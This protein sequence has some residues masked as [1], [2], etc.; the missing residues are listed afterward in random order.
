MSL[1]S[2][3][4]YW[5]FIWSCIHF[6]EPT[7]LG[8]GCYRNTV[9]DIYIVSS[10]CFFQRFCPSCLSLR[11]SKLLFF[12]FC[13]L[14]TEWCFFTKATTVIRIYVH[15]TFSL[16]K[17]TLWKW[18]DFTLP[19]ICSATQW[20]WARLQVRTET[21]VCST[22]PST[23]LEDWIHCLVFSIFRHYLRNKIPF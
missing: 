4:L 13:R 22:Q 1:V 10:N 23:P 12:C 9:F 11:N 2:L 15:Q 8:I 7:I 18:E 16:E 19:N 3:V 5:I 17:G 6:V 20:W 14:Q 21:V